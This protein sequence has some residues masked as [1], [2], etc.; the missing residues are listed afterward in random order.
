M[1]SKSSAS[2]ALI[3]ARLNSW[4]ASS[5][6]ASIC[7]TEPGGADRR[8]MLE[9]LAQHFEQDGSRPAE[10]YDTVHCGHRPNQPPRLHRR[11]IAVTER[12]VIDEG[13]IEQIAAG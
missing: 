7:R 3:S 4:T 6:L 13:E 9:R 5:S 11:D 2:S 8:E 1:N 12:R 10:H